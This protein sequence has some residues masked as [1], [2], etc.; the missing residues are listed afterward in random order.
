MST[1]AVQRQAAAK[2]EQ[3]VQA[4]VLRARQAIN[5]EPILSNLFVKARE[6]NW[7][8]KRL[9]DSLAVRLSAHWGGI[10]FDLALNVARVLAH[11]FVDAPK[12]TAVS[13][14]ASDGGI[15]HLGAESLW[16]PGLVPRENG[17]LAQP[18]TRLRPEIEAQLMHQV[19]EQSRETGIVAEAAQDLAQTSYLLEEGDPRLHVLTRQ[20]RKN[21]LEGFIAR[22]QTAI[23]GHT[24]LQTLTA[25]QSAEQP[26]RRT[27]AL[28]PAR[29]QRQLVTSQDLTTP[30]CGPLDGTTL[31]IQTVTNIGLHDLRGSNLHFDHAEH[32]VQA[33]LSAWVRQIC[34]ATIKNVPPRLPL[35]YPNDRAIPVTEIIQHAAGR[36]Y[37]LALA[38]TGIHRELVQASVPV[39]CLPEA[40]RVYLLY[41]P[42]ADL[43]VDLNSV[44]TTCLEF[45]D[46]VRYCTVATLN[47]HWRE[48]VAMYAFQ[49]TPPGSDVFVAEIL[50]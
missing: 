34:S 30:L 10:D 40:S 44:R 12:N 31:T 24:L 25:I 38:P 27:H 22:L 1:E 43:T 14:V 39:I 19:A 35:D 29:S 8:T 9:A 32:I 42:V 33:V 20:G 13:L 18:L 11:E 36:P 50:R 47:L 49:C 48:N 28:A 21:I 5:A 41:E 16:Q 26:L 4:A 23:Q 46:R 37:Y 2:A 7:E 45:H 3:Q 6:D 15:Q 17:N